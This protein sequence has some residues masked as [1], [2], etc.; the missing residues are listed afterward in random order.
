[1]RLFE[2]RQICLLNKIET[3][4]SPSTFALA[5]DAASNY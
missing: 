4:F 2:L 3:G 5:E 1:M